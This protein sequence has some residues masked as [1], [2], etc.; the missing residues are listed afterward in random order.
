[1]SFEIA[2]RRPG[3]VASCYAN[4]TLA[5]EFLDWR[6]GLGLDDMMRD[7]WRWQSANPHG[8]SDKT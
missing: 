1:M 5:E 4:P 8:Y 7:T 6:A 2:A 3:D